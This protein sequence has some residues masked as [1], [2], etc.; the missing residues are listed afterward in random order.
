MSIE[1]MKIYTEQFNKEFESEI[2]L[3]NKEIPTLLRVFHDYIEDT[4]KMNNLYKK[5][6]DKIVDIEDVLNNSFTEEQKKLFD[7]WEVYRDEMNNLTAEQS[8]VYGFCL[9]K[10][11]SDEKQ[12]L[13]DFDEIFETD[14]LN[15]IKFENAKL[16]KKLYSLF[17]EEIYTP[18]TEYKNLLHQYNILVEELS[19]TFT[20]KQHDLHTKAMEIKNQM[21]DEADGQ[22][23]LFGYIIAKEIEKETKL[24]RD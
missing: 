3:N 4:F 7:K 20:E 21:S 23:F 19:E 5:I 24:S 17:K 15:N 10:E 13:K 1:N 18:S 2:K 14:T 6:L 8:F 11:L 12:I 22:L 9:D 16:L